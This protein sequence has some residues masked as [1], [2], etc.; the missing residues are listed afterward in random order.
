MTVATATYPSRIP[1]LD[2]VRGVAVMG[3]LV[4]NIVAFAMPFPAYANPAAYGGDTGL[5]YASWV[6]NFLI[7]DGKMRGLFSILFGASTLLVIERASAS[8]RAAVSDRNGTPCA[9]G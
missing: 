4:M 2:I 7:F 9:P 6:F 5:D 1:T 3:I 8:S